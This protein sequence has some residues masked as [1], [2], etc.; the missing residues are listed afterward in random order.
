ML[1]SHLWDVNS[2]MKYMPIL[3]DIFNKRISPNRHALITYVVEAHR[4]SVS[5]VETSSLHVIS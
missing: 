2:E 3:E 5:Y 4:A 1:E